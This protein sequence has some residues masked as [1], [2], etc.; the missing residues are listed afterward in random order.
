[1]ISNTDLTPREKTSIYT[2]N[3]YYVSHIC[4][5]LTE[6][7]N[8]RNASTLI[9]KYPNNDQQGQRNGQQQHQRQQI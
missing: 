9:L 6:F 3:L 2:F 8:V 4:P 5:Y 1:M 7:Q